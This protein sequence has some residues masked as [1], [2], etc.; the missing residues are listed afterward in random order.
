MPVD[1][2]TQLIIDLLARS[3]A[4][5]LINGTPQEART[6]PRPAARADPSTTVQIGSVDE[7]QYITGP[8]GPLAIRIYRPDTAGPTPT[9]VF[10]HGGGMVTGDLDSHDDHG[11][12]ICRD[13]DAVVVSVEYRL[14]PEWP[15]PSAFDDCMTATRWA[16]ENISTLGGDPD[17]LAV[18][19]DSAGGNLAA[20]VAIAARKSGPRLAAQLLV[21]PK[22]DLT[23]N[24]NYRSRT[25]NAEGYYLTSELADWFQDHYIS[26]DDVRDPRA[27]VI[28]A[29]DLSGVAPAVIGV[30]QYDLLRDEVEA[31]AE[32]LTGAGV[33]VVFHRF[34]G[35]IHGFYGMGLMSVAAADAVS[36]LNADFRRL[37][38]T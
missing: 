37:L 36:T 27:S 28:L 5:D 1:P 12:L 11:R 16:A 2:Q 38:H 18:A 13:V 4:A 34:D 9:V 35:L 21:Y 7:D 3:G 23:E 14:A 32:R 24:G 22:T 20:A 6:F 17:R 15:F 30:G 33:E 31:Y 25:D 8:G 26:K 29:D 19:G 10:F